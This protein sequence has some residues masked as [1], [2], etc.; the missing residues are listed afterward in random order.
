LVSDWVVIVYLG[1][2]GIL[3]THSPGQLGVRKR[4]ELLH[5]DQ[6]DVGDAFRL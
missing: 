3:F 5:S 2:E 4:R 1:M 6:R